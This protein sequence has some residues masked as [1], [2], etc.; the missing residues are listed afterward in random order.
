MSKST[1]VFGTVLAFCLASAAAN[2][3]GLTNPRPL[4]LVFHALE[5][6][7]LAVLFVGSIALSVTLS[8]A[9]VR[10]LVG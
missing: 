6:I 1:V 2:F 4:A 9:L 7:D 8:A 5:G 3:V 10:K